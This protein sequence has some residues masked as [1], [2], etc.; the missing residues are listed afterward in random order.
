M[1]GKQL[2]YRGEGSFQT[3]SADIIRVAF[4][5]QSDAIRAWLPLSR[6]L[7]RAATQLEV[8][9]AHKALWRNSRA[10]TLMRA[11]LEAAAHD[12]FPD[13]PELWAL[14]ANAVMNILHEDGHA[15]RTP[16]QVAQDE[17]DAETSARQH[18]AWAEEE[19]KSDDAIWL[20]RQNRK[21]LNRLGAPGTVDRIAARIVLGGA[22]TEWVK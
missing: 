22:E 6:F 3:L 9:G 7:E 21:F 15:Q 17:R 5:D 18:A 2:P 16:E 13:A 12:E 20:A 14:T 4:T 19:R 10:D 8:I 11:S 1:L